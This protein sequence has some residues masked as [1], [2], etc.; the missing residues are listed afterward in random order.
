M[1][2]ILRHVGGVLRIG[3]LG[4]GDVVRQLFVRLYQL[5]KGSVVAVLGAFYQA[6][7]RRRG[8]G[9]F[10]RLDLRE[11]EQPRHGG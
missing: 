8:F 9:F 5:L 7:L 6:V 3:D 10:I 1:M 11:L 4:I 2:N